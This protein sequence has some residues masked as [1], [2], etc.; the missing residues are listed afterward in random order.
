MI[1]SSLPD[2]RPHVRGFSKKRKANVHSTYERFLIGGHP[3]NMRVSVHAHSTGTLIN[4]HMNFPAER[5][6]QRLLDEVFLNVQIR[7]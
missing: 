5:S 2:L 7:S 1:A 6:S 4:M 3:S